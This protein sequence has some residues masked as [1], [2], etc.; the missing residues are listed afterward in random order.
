MK[1]AKV[2]FSSTDIIGNTRKMTVM[3]RCNN[4]NTDGQ[5]VIITDGSIQLFTSTKL[6][7]KI[8]NGINFA[9]EIYGRES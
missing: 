9:F 2:V 1:V 3:K 7:R 4:N 6:P 8:G 5:D